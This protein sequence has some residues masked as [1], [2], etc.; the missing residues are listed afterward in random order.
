M[1]SRFWW[2]WRSRGEIAREVDEELE[3]HL[4]MRAAEL[5]RA[6][7]GPEEAR[8]EAER[9]FGDLDATRRVCQADDGMGDRRRRWR[10][11]VLDLRGDL[12]A[13]WRGWRRTPVALTVAVG[14]LAVGIGAAA[15]VF[16]I[17]DGVLFK[18]LPYRQSA[19][20]MAVYQF[21][22]RKGIL[23]RPSP[24]NFLD[25]RERLTRL[26]IAAAEP[27][28]MTL[29]DATGTNSALSAFLVTD[30]YFGVLG[31]DPLVGRDFRPDEFTPGRHRQ[32]ILGHATWLG[33][34]GGDR[35]VIGRTI[36]L[37]GS[38]HQVV[39]V[40]PPGIEYP[41]GRDIYLPK[42]FDPEEREARARTYFR[43][44][45]RLARDATA[46]QA[47]AEFAQI[48]GALAR[49]YPV[50]N[51]NV[52]GRLVPLADDISGRV[53]GG[54]V[55]MLLAVGLVVVVAMV[56]VAG[57]LMTRAAHRR[58][59]L[60]VRLALG[61][62][63]ARLTRLAAVEGFGLAV[64]ASVVGWLIA[65]GAVAV[66][67][68]MAPADLPRLS[69]I[70][71]DLRSVLVLAGTGLLTAIVCG[72]LPAHAAAMI[73]DTEAFRR[74]S[75]GGRGAGSTGRVLV[76]VEVALAV[77][78]L[79]AAGL[80]GRSFLKLTDQDLGYSTDRRV[81]AT[82][83][84]WDRYRSPGQLVGFAERALEEL[85]AVPGVRRAAVAN[86]L[87]LSAVGSEMDPPFL[88]EGQ[89]P[90][91]P[92][93]EPTARVTIVSL[94]YFDAL[95]IP[96]VAGRSF[97]RGDVLGNRRVIV[98]GETLARR[99]WPGLDPIGRAIQVR[100]RDSGLVRLEVVGVVG[101]TRFAG[102]GDRPVPEYYVPLAQRPFGSLTFVVHAAGPAV[103]FAAIQAAI[104]RVD[105]SI[106]V[107]TFETLDSLLA[108][109]LATRRFILGAALGFAGVAILL[110]AVGL[111]GLLSLLV[112]QRLPE[113]GVRLALGASRTNLLALIAGQGGG[114]AG[115]GV[116]LGIGGAILARRW[117][118]TQ[119]WG[120]EATDPTTFVAIAVGTL[121]VAFAASAVPAIRACRV[122]PVSTL[123]RE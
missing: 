109:T 79:V 50:P 37:D 85:A 48:T 29:T 78:L 20:V 96:L 97:D 38:P 86:A 83:H 77:S 88:V 8:Q 53:R 44:V 102:H 100:G 87:P 19:Q 105:G 5:E 21:E 112:S 12:S 75:G 110:A 2:P 45:G 31:V 117:L 84:V 68:W 17:V 14:T 89:A 18:P 11:A 119:V 80:L 64:T 73:P 58:T 33:R 61:A 90:P 72:V 43:V 62:G 6:G 34:F 54:L 120:I 42:V 51:A 23:E 115:L 3:F 59:E 116:I 101:D 52:V 7:W 1:G 98:V 56:N 103:T 27:Y 32:V 10:D 99:V 69:A 121:L 123:K 47:A 108:G 24:G 60:A 93:Q 71:L 49:Q 26:R 76:V 57:L 106:A 92:G 13:A 9:E 41:A 35:G 118:A 82:V 70:E 46:D 36:T 114:L 55:L 107:S 95:G 113:I 122:D 66:A 65:R 111:Y 39:G 25:W 40:L 15:G 94:D 30:G 22:S 74:R 63:R 16:S 91:L 4:A 67:L 28:G 81:L 104:A